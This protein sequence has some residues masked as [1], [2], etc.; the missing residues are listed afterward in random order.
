RLLSP[1]PPFP[2]DSPSRLMFRF[3][4]Q[5]NQ[6]SLLRF[7][8][9]RSPCCDRRAANRISNAQRVQKPLRFSHRLL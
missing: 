2:A 1:R 5:H 6:A 7:V 9:G 3:T 8:T 4:K